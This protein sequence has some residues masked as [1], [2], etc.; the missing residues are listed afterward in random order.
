M[1]E[2][3]RE[4]ELAKGND[5]HITI[6]KRTEEEQGVSKKHLKDGALDSTVREL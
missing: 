4:H 3:F 1:R 6:E 5:H 2:Q